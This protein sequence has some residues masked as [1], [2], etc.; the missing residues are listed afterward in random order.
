MHF[1]LFHIFL[2]CKINLK[3]FIHRFIYSLLKVNSARQ[4]CFAVFLHHASSVRHPIN[5]PC[6]NW[7]GHS[8]LARHELNLIQHGSTPPVLSE[9]QALDP[10]LIG[11][12][13]KNN[14]LHKNT[15]KP[16]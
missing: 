9:Q 1:G 2:N 15:L 3:H 16:L 6:V 7:H 4:D 5:H 8:F 11:F 14:T 12:H 13:F 10:K